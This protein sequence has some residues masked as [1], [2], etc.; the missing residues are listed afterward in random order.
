MLA[1]MLPKVTVIL[2]VRNGGDVLSRTVAA[3][4]AQDRQPEALY[5]VTDDARTLADIDTGAAKVVLIPQWVSFGAAVRSA[6]RVLDA[7]TSD[8]DSLWLLTEDSAPQPSALAM[9]LGSLETSKSVVI[10]A[11]KLVQW[12][13][14][15]RIALF[16]RSMTRLG[17]AG[18]LVA[19]ELDQG[20]HDDVSDVLGVN[21][22][23]MLIRQTVWRELDGFDP[24]LPIVDDGLDLAIR[25]RLAGYR[26]EMV[27]LARVEFAQNGVAGP[28]VNGRARLAR[29]AG[30]QAR[31]AQ[32]YRRLVYARGIL[33]PFF[34][35][36]LLPLAL[37]RAF[38]HIVQKM[39]GRI[40]GEIRATLAVM[41]RFGAL[42]R[43]RRRLAEHRV[44]SWSALSSLRIQPR[45]A[46]AMRQNAQ[47]AR[48][49]RAQLSADGVE[50]LDTG[51]GWVLLGSVVATVALFGWLLAASE[52][53]GA[54]LLPLSDSVSTLWRNAAYGWRDI[55]AGFAGPADPFAGVLAVLGSLTFWAPSYSLV[56]LWL[57][58]IPV[59]ALGGWFAASRFTD[60]GILRATAAVLWALSPSL[61]IA[62]G[63]GRVGAVIAHI[64]LAWLAYAVVGAARSWAATGA[65]SLLL[66]ATVAGSPS[67]GPALLAAL[68]IALVLTRGMLPR[69][70]W[71]V[72]PTLALWA[73]LVIAQVRRGNPL[74][75]L[76]DPGVPVAS[77]SPS[78]WQLAIGYPGK[79]WGGWDFQVAGV[80][81]HLLAGILIVPL[82]LCALAALTTPRFRYAV[83]ALGVAALGFATAVAAGH[84]S[85]STV[86]NTSVSV[87]A[88][89][90]LSL[91]WLGLTLAAIM[92][93]ASFSR[94]GALSGVAV[95]ATALV[96]VLPT[97]VGLAT[98]RVS[99]TGSLGRAL[100][101]YVQAQAEVNPQV[102]TL[103]LVPAANGSMQVTLERG[104]GTTLDQ[105]STFARTTAALTPAELTLAEVVGNLASRS[106]YDPSSAI[107]AFGVSFVLLSDAVGSER[108]TATVQARAQ[109][110][111]DGN[112]ALTAV[113]KTDYGQLWRFN[114]EV[115]AV[116]PA[117]ANA[118]SI[119]TG[120]AVLQLAALMCA[121]L[122]AIPIGSAEG[123]PT[124]PV[125]RPVA[126]TRRQ[127]RER[128]THTLDSD[129]QEADDEL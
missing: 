68:V 108:A 7:P 77:R 65:A 102:T 59:A 29:R 56:V 79:S 100:P 25:A 42:A 36:S 121:V 67:L 95:A 72:L 118:G 24:A 114:D 127:R 115:P 107:R 58:A 4:R 109:A 78:V 55:G 116:L 75:L 81:I 34:W 129:D 82:A 26:V 87:W 3:L 98:G 97:A 111:L 63:D 119:P 10:S 2:V 64:L 91:E 120:V 51:G 89:S 62:L 52:L 124:G 37:I 38:G 113:G 47:Q 18:P 80:N 105:Q 40:G 31:T 96:A 126:V 15:D 41:F 27:P 43:S 112:S 20:Q 54:G 101:A 16:G 12:D 23:G 53:T 21:P 70:F 35:L 93:C 60:R 11:P 103:R 90:G 22:A 13:Q 9:L 39:P 94:L 128:Q 30:R 28:R 73:P 61:L 122:L 44:T 123:A 83:C 71:I 17:R 69:C 99:L 110:A 49:A 45:E 14:P 5:F 125:L 88:G 84:L 104:T 46:R 86:G 33:V 57:C 19:D 85:L 32:L 117:A 76:A 50:F 106:G 66:A 48:R 6:E 8:A 74:G 92:A 1:V